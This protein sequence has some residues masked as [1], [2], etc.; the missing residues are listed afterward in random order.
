MASSPDAPSTDAILQ[1]PSVEERIEQSKVPI[2]HVPFSSFDPG[3]FHVSLIKQG[4]Y[5]KRDTNRFLSRA[6][7][8]EHGITKGTYSGTQAALSHGYSLIE[9]SFGSYYNVLQIERTLPRP[10]SLSSKQT[11]FEWSDYP[12]EKNGDRAF[13][14][15]HLETI[16]D[17][18]QHKNYE[19]FDAIGLAETIYL[20]KLLVPDTF[21][22][23]AAKAALDALGITEKVEAFFREEDGDN[24]D[25]WNQGL[26]LK[27]YE[28]YNLTNRKSGIDIEQG[29]NIG[30]LPDWYSDR[31]FAE[32]SFTG[33]NPTSIEKVSKALLDEFIA[34]AKSG[35]YEFWAHY[36]AAADLNVLFVQDT[37]YFREAAGVKPNDE[38]LHKEKSS[39][40]NWACAAVSLYELH[41]DGKLHPIAIVCDY[42]TSMANSV[43]IFNKRKGPD[44]TSINQETDWPWRYAKTCAQV[45][46]WF[47]HEVGVHLTRAHMIEEALIV[48]THRQI[49]EE[50]IVFKILQ[51]HWYKTLSLN[52]AARETLVPQL[53]KDLVGFSPDQTSRYVCYEF[54]NFNFVENYVPE[55]LKRRGFPDSSEGLSDDKYKNYAY[56]KNMVSMWSSIRGYVEKMLKT[57]YNESVPQFMGKTLDEMVV[58]DNY[59]QEWCYEVQNKGWIKTFPTIQTFDQLCDAVTMCIH[60]AAPFHTAVNYLQNFYQSF[61]L[62]KPSALCHALPKSLT[63]LLKYEEKDLMQALPCGRQREWLLSV[64]IPWLLSSQ[65]ASERSLK[66]FALS[67]WRIHF[68][69]QSNLDKD[70]AEISKE[71]Y[72]DL[73]RLDVEFAQTSNN[74]DKGSVP[75]MVLDPDNTAVSILI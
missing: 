5:M 75:Y 74:M 64:Q 29:H 56:A 23:K 63:E 45:S 48:A 11:T 21:F 4:L 36:L 28:E 27:A 18:E 58:G 68:K 2:E 38:L 35:K 60:I 25:A 59:I 67:Q 50:H 65:V 54:E 17:G 47:R 52:A 73:Q 19:I 31:R 33:T 26:T 57:Q 16:P 55:D 70:I 20:L 32:Q 12:K 37:R 42:K 3:A 8:N 30:E 7:V 61:V 15:P 49:P 44:D 41:S 71:F 46:D 14:P 24:Y 51:P 66:S 39:D 6:P 72:E 10:T 1:Q 40:K 13:Y 22:G 69:G 62:A 34:A 53:I 43:T 9:Q